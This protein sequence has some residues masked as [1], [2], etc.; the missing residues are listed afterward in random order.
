MRGET[1][2][3]TPKESALRRRLLCGKRWTAMTR[4]LQVLRSDLEQLRKRFALL[5]RSQSEEA[6][7]EE[8]VVAHSERD[9]LRKELED[10]QLLRDRYLR[11][12][13]DLSTE[14][15]SLRFLNYTL[16]EENQRLKLGLAGERG[17]SQSL[18]KKIEILESQLS[19][20]KA[21]NG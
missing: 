21:A 6:L 19:I 14:V 5:Q 12:V 7:A 1:R 20:K 3:D 15:A 8:I 10:T 2:T 13:N 4:E 18:R 17:F 16:H 11:L 9:R